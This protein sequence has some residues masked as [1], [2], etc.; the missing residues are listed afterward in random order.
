MIKMPNKFCREPSEKWY[1][2]HR[3]D[4][5]IK[6]RFMSKL[7]EI[8]YPP[9]DDH[10]RVELSCILTIY[11]DKN[12]QKNKLSIQMKWKMWNSWSKKLWFCCVF[13]WTLNL[14]RISYIVH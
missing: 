3:S 10:G 5:D 6:M 2:K 8:T 4:A 12:A 7:C 9:K 13:G 1:Y 14:E 11:L